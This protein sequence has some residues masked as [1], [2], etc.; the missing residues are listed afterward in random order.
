[1]RKFCS[2]ELFWEGVR[3]KKHINP[4]LQRR[5]RC[6]QSEIL[7][8]DSLLNPPASVSKGGS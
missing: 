5:D 1:M 7:T 8:L 2:Q 6:I 3:R 4:L